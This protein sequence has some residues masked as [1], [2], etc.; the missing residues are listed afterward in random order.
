MKRGRPIT[1]GPEFD[2][3]R[4][5]NAAKNRRWRK[6]NPGKN[7]R[8]VKAW[9]EKN[10]DAAV[11]ATDSWRK[12]RYGIPEG[13]Y[14]R[15]LVSQNGVCAICRQPEKNKRKGKLFRLSIDHHHDSGK[16][17]GLLCANCNRAIGGMAEDPATLRAAAD[18]LEKHQ[19]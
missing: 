9:R 11:S 19:Q 18:Y 4:A 2:A 3:E 10:R 13:E 17:R 7:R 14:D 16:V 5:D 6:S 15:M 12:R 1:R 8:S